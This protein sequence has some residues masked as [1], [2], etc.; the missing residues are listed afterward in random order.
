MGRLVSAQRDDSRVLL[1]RAKDD[2]AGRMQLSAAYC[3]DGSWAG[4]RVGELVS[5]ERVVGTFLD[6]HSYWFSDASNSFHEAREEC[7]VLLLAYVRLLRL[8]DGLAFVWEAMIGE[9]GV[10]DYWRF[11]RGV[12]ALPRVRLG[13]HVPGPSVGRFS[14]WLGLVEYLFGKFDE[15]VDGSFDVSVVRKCNWWQRWLHGRRRRYDLYFMLPALGRS[16]RERV[17]GT[18][19]EKAGDAAGAGVKSGFDECEVWRLGWEAFIKT[20][21]QEHWRCACSVGEQVVWRVRGVLPQAGEK[22]V[23]SKEVSGG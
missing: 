5:V 11:S 22:Q 4:W 12:D 23:G 18:T 17:R 13:A 10:R 20:R 14:A 19:G 15:F 21:G 9:Q 8:D 3:D 2:F 7:R 6:L 1:F 16:A